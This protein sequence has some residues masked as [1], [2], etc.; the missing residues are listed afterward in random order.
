[1]VVVSG[2]LEGGEEVGG[3]IGWFSLRSTLEC[4]HELATPT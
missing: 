4:G 3:D 1:M 2:G